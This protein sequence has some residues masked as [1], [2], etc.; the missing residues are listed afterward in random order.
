MSSR[1]RSVPTRARSPPPA[2]MGRCGCGTRAPPPVASPPSWATPARR[3]RRGVQSRRPHAGLRRRGWDGAAVGRARR[4]ALGTP[5]R[6]TPATSTR[7][8]SVLT[9]ARWP[10]PARRDGA[11]VGRRTPPPARHP[12]RGTIQTSFTRWRSVPTGARWPPPAPIRRCDCGTP[13]SGATNRSRCAT[14]SARPSITTSA[15]PTGTASSPTS[16]IT[17]PA[18]ESGGRWLWPAGGRRSLRAGTGRA[19][20]KDARRSTRRT[21]RPHRQSR[22]HSDG[23]LNRRVAC[24]SIPLALAQGAAIAPPANVLILWRNALKASPSS[25][26]GTFAC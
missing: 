23:P 3:L 18:R 2:L 7:W 4:R 13:S 22:P 8:R 12:P 24:Y 17:A 10:P 9:G 21:A 20:A 14:A 1:W 5:L 11:A 6:A 25:K 16:P 15:R 26:L 19:P